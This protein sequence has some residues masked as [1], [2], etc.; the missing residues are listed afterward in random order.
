MACLSPDTRTYIGSKPPDQGH[1][2]GR[3]ARVSVDGAWFAPGELDINPGLVA[4]IGPRGSGKTALADLISAGAGC[5][6]PFENGASFLNRAGRL[7]NGASALVEWTH[8]EHKP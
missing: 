8:G 3:V 4:I 6:E 7:L 5:R 1:A 2:Y